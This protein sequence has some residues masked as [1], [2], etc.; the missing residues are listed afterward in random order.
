MPEICHDEPLGPHVLDV[1]LVLAQDALVDHLR[2]DRGTK[3][4]L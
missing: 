4:Y 2:N 3:Y 1:L